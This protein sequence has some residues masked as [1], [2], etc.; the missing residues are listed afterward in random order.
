M[1]EWLVTYVPAVDREVACVAVQ[2]WRHTLMHTA[3]PR[4]LR[5][6]RIGREYMCLLHWGG[7]VPAEQ[8]LTILPGNPANLQLALL[9]L[10]SDLQSALGTFSADVRF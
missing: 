7:E 10:I 5:D 2:M 4:R 8:H 6:D 1:V 9:R 3:Q